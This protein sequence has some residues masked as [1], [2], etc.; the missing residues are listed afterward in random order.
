MFGSDSDD[1]RTRC[2]TAPASLVGVVESKGGKAN[3]FKAET[4]KKVIT[5]ETD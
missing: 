4:L 2:K 5:W 3:S 1:V